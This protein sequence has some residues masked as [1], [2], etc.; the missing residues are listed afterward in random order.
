[1]NATHTRQALRPASLRRFHLFGPRRSGSLV[2]MHGE[3]LLCCAADS[4]TSKRPVDEHRTQSLDRA[5]SLNER[6]QLLLE[7]ELQVHYSAFF[8]DDSLEVEQLL[9][10]FVILW[11]QPLESRLDVAL[12]ALGIRIPVQSWRT[13]P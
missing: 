6:L 7:Q 12:I 10:R 3:Q 11:K 8:W 2:G 4:R 5:R 1:M 13:K 9:D